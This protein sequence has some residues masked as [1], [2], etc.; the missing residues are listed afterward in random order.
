[1]IIAEWPWDGL[2]P[3]TSVRSLH[4]ITACCNFFS[5]SRKIAVDFRSWARNHVFT[6]NAIGL[7]L[8]RSLEVESHSVL[9]NANPSVDRSP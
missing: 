7:D 3:L 5:A 6:L 1:M 9:Y 4:K 2:L 8:V